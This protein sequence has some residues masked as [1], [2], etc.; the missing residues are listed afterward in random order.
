MQPAMDLGRVVVRL[1]VV[2]VD[3]ADRMRLDPAI[4]QFIPA[5]D[6]ELEI[7]SARAGCPACGRSE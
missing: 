3:L 2:A 1:R 5:A 4:E 6:R 7:A